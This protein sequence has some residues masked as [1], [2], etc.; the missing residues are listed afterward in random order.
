MPTYRTASFSHQRLATSWRR[1]FCTSPRASPA[2]AAGYTNAVLETCEGL[3]LF[4]LRG[5]AREDIR[6]G[7]R[8][9][10]HQ[11]RTVIAYVVQE[12]ELTVA[13]LGVFYRGQDHEGALSAW[14]R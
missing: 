9:T 10:H 2:V 3:A 12:P 14:V 7:L 4:L 13:V 6:P 1:C 11:G 8:L 5:L